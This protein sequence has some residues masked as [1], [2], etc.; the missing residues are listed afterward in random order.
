M[1]TGGE[2]GAIKGQ[3]AALITNPNPGFDHSKTQCRKRAVYPGVPSPDRDWKFTAYQERP[4]PRAEAR[5]EDPA[6]IRSS[7]GSAP[8]TQEYPA[9]TETGRLPHTKNDPDPERK[10][11]RRTQPV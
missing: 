10:R 6:C 7:A 4:R 5:Q 3:S 11:A 1:A 8:Y 9:Q 2:G